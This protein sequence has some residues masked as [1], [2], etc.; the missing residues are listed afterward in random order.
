MG[1]G[2]RGRSIGEVAPDL[3][4]QWHPTKNGPNSPDNISSG[5]N[6]KAWWICEKGHEW[7]SVIASRVREKLG[8]PYCSGRYVLSGYNDLATKNAT[9][10]SEWHPTKNGDLLPTSVPPSGPQKVWWLGKCGHEWQTTVNSR[11][12][13]SGCP[14][15]A[16]QK[17][18]AGFNDLSTRQPQLIS[19]W[20]PNKNS[21]VQPTQVIAGSNKK[22]W[23]M[24]KEGHEWEAAP[25]SRQKAG[26]GVCA[27]Q[28]L[29]AGFN[30]LETLYPRVASRWH[31]TKNGA[32]RPSQVSPSNKK[33]HWWMCEEGHEWESLAYPM[34]KSLASGCPACAGK[35]VVSGFNDI[36]TTDPEVS[37]EWHPDLNLPLLPSEVPRGTRKKVWWRCKEGHEWQ[38]I[39]ANRTVSGNKCPYCQ[40]QW[41]LVGENDL[42]T[43][44]PELAAEWHPTK[45]RPTTPNDV[46][47]TTGKK[48][49]WLG[50]CGHEWEAKVSNRRSL[51]LGCPIC[52]NQR[53]LTGFNDL[54]TLNP[55][56]A[57]EWHPTKNGDLSPK[58]IAPNRDAKAW[59]LG[60]CGHEWKADVGSRHSGNGCPK[61]AKGGYDQTRPGY[62]YLMRKELLDLQ[63]F[64]ISNFPD[65]RLAT[66]KKNHWEV[67]DVIGPADGLWI[68]ETETALKRFFRYKKVL[69]PPDYG[70]KFDGFSETWDSS[71]LQFTKIT[72][73]LE[74]LRQFED[75]QSSNSKNLDS[76]QGKQSSA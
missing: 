61:C 10:A 52:S 55:S 25:N 49:W 64:G 18:L 59:W 50:E 41:L 57:R 43:L 7:E 70:D 62:L 35:K 68:L 53:V 9:L 63:Q 56:L 71:A 11:A 4:N 12:R 60:E 30:D 32:L 72:D 37:K 1:S 40:H 45:N 38:A 73:M 76:G 46:F 28:I 14:F 21:P 54:E 5:S 34:T 20:H 27:G 19:E 51:G 67:L 31:P 22:Y 42:A 13:G 58:D 48:Y 74:A 29:L 66:H 3:C 39:I 2:F 69:L 6:R 23:W 24:C 75:D 65:R 16:N 17:V 33:K 44:A 15:C 8:C 47:A 26:C 36:L